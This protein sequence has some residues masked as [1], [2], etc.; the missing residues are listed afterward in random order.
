MADPYF[1]DR[2][3]DRIGG[4]RF[5]KET[6]IYK[7]EKIKRAKRRVLAEHPDR[8]LL[9]FGIGENDAMAPEPIRRILSEEA[10]RPENRGYADNGITEFKEAAARFMERN[11]GVFLDPV[12]QV[13][14]CIGT[15][16]ALAMFPAAWINPGDVTLI[17]VPG[18]PIAATHT[19]YYGG[20]VHSLPLVAERDFFPDL[21]SIPGDILARA[22][23]LVLNYPNSPTGKTATPDFYAHVVDFAHQHR[24]VVI[25]DAAH[26]MLSYDRPPTSFL[27]TPGAIDVGVELHSMSKGFNMIGW[28]IGWICG[29]ARLVHAF[30][31][32]KDNCDSGQ[33]I[34]I[35]KAAA[36]AL[37]DD[38]I[39]QGIRDKYHRRLEKLVSVLQRCGFTCQMPGG[40]YFLYTR[41]PSKRG[42]ATFA[43][44]EEV[45]QFLIAEQSICTVPWD[46]AGPYLRFSVTYEAADGTGED[47]LMAEL[48]ARMQ[49]LH[50]AWE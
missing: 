49:K 41:A 8:R 47:S 17:T 48:E 26:A 38:T 50:L 42:N 35:Q 6:E 21:D 36:A 3:A 19:R 39:H 29:H 46:D 4:A 30:A 1:Q 33:F 2:F 32:I 12:T 10:G 34:P 24:L 45:S 27:A 22:K 43:S 40:S 23:L 18:Y 7:F 15:K 37:D 9:D 20:T 25:Q 5:G 13:N 16:S 14:H 31:D 28:R 44:A 11:F